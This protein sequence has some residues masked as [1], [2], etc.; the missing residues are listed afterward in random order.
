MNTMKT[1]TLIATIDQKDKLLPEKMNIQTDA[2]VANQCGR[3]SKEE[4]YI[5]G[6]RVLYLNTAERGVGKN[7]NLLLNNA[8]GDICIM[9][10]DDMRFVDGYKK[11]AEKAFEECP[12][13]D[14]LVFNL[15]EKNPKRYINK[16]IVRVRWN[17]YAKYG[18]ARIVFKREKIVASGVR[19]SLLFGGGAIY[20][21]GED[22][23]FLHD[24]LKKRL[25]IYAVPHALAEIDQSA[26]STWFEGYNEKFF[27]DKGALYACL[28]PAGWLLYALRYVIKYRKRYGNYIPVLQALKHMFIG[29]K[30]YIA[31]RKV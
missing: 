6:H 5:N 4:D 3:I 8:S 25:R 10:D 20:G 16:K 14:I 22:T 31:E 21:S 12:L 15:I 13:A 11:I 19:F 29:G 24:C 7:R 23:I 17:N 28:H 18:A 1:E 2:V 30:E 26:P 27:H 9:A